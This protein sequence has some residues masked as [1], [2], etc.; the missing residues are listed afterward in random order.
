[1]IK[2]AGAPKSSQAA[3]ILNDDEIKM[4]VADVTHIMSQISSLT[5]VCDVYLSHEQQKFS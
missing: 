4:K 1:M 2:E 3:L 5:K